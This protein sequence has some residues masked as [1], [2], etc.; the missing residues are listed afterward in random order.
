MFKDIIQLIKQWQ[1]Q[2]EVV[3]LATGVFDI[4]H[5]EHLRF[6]KKARKAGD[7]LLVGLESD[8]RVKA[9]KGHE[10]PLNDQSI[11]LEQLQTL[12]AVDDAFLLPQEFN[13]QAQWEALM[14]QLQPDVYAVSSH[15]KHQENKR[16]IC[17]KFGIS[18]Q[19]V[20]EY[21][22]DFSSSALIEKIKATR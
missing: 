21:N 7:R 19:I 2:G 17:Q 16:Q 14:S 5:I 1:S 20:H 15:T 11:R 12:K 13:T 22:P 18:F 6:L 8:A 3:V 10:R 4:L 9:I